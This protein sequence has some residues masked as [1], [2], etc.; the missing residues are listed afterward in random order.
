MLVSVEAADE[1][2]KGGRRKGDVDGRGEFPPDPAVS[3]RRDFR[4]L[5]AIGCVVEGPRTTTL[6]T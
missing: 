2:E 5:V 3:S 1:K 4:G 6:G